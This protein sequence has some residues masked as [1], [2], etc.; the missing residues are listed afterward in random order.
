M[1]FVSKKQRSF[2]RV[3][4]PEVARRWTEKYGSA[5]QSGE[6]KKSFRKPKHRKEKGK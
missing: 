2:L 1:P 6:F 4:H 5:I 3:R